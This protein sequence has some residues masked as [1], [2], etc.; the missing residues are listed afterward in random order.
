[1]N[2]NAFPD[3]LLEDLLCENVPERCDKEGLQK[4]IDGLDKKQTDILL[5]H[6]RDKMS[7]P[8]IG[9][10]MGITVH[11]TTG[12]ANKALRQLRRPENRRLYDIQVMG[13]TQERNL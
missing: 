8:K 12:I 9:L 1:M 3:N 7:Y 13:K 4:A 2:K 10:A 6:Y 11:Q 5:M